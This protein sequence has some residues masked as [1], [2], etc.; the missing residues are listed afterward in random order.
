[1]WNITSGY[2]LG[3][4]YASKKVH[5]IQRNVKNSPIPSP[6]PEPQSQNKTSQED[7]GDFTILL[8][9]LD[10]KTIT[11]ASIVVAGWV[12]ISQVKNPPAVVYHR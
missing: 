2:I 12:R 5:I 3:K 8:A 1:M 7:N 9:V 6:P 4:N 11:M 10:Y